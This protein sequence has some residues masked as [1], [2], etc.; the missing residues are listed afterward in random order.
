MF[1]GRFITPA[2]SVRQTL[3]HRCTDKLGHLCAYRTAILKTT[4]EHDAE[5]APAPA[6]QDENRREV[7]HLARIFNAVSP[8]PVR[9]MRRVAFH[10]MGDCAAYH[11]TISTYLVAATK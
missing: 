10:Q 8:S 3:F 9:A 6:R 11:K 5:C 4:V 2:F 7:E 1:A